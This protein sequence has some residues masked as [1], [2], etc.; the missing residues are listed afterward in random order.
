MAKVLSVAV[1]RLLQELIVASSRRHW[2]MLRLVPARW[3]R[4][5]VAPTA[6][7]LRRS[8]ARVALATAMSI[9]IFLAVMIIRP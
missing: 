6:L 3:L 4:A 2:P 1:D 9:G 8:L 7:R 5:A